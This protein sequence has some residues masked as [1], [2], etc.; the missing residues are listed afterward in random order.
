MIN[1]SRN[2]KSFKGI[3]F[4]FEIRKFLFSNMVMIAICNLGMQ[5][6]VAEKRA[7]RITPEALV[8]KDQ[9]IPTQKII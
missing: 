6:E 5:A 1:C 8:L 4:F 9:R 3:Y 2:S 7:E